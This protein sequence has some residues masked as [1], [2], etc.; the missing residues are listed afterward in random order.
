[1]PAIAGK[2]ASGRILILRIWSLSQ[3]RLRSIANQ[4]PDE[5]NNKPKARGFRA[6]FEVIRIYKGDSALHFITVDS[7][8]SDCSIEFLEER[9]I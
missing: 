1:M 5:K 7:G 9:N 2:L 4:Y 8:L 6:E 3:K